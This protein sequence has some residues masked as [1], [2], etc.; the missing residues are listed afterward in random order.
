MEMADTT[1]SRLVGAFTFVNLTVLVANLVGAWF[2]FLS[3]GARPDGVEPGY[4]PWLGAMW[5]L[6]PLLSVSGLAVA[7]VSRGSVWPRWV[8][9]AICAAYVTLW[10]VVLAV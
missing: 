1:P 3:Y 5:I 9:A 6:G 8:N 2:L 10:A 7:A 4:R